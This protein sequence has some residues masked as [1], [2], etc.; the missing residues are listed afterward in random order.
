MLK[1][2]TFPG[3]CL[4]AFILPTKHSAPNPGSQ[5]IIDAPHMKQY[6]LVQLLSGQDRTQDSAVAVKIQAAHIANIERLHR[7]G[8][9]IMA[10]PMG[11]DKD[12]RGIFILDA[13]DSA[14]AA[15]LVNTDPAVK[16]GRLRFE[17]HPW[18]CQTGTYVFK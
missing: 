8:S 5:S 18:W 4:L 16:A 12:W 15:S 10:G 1:L 9:L 6:W 2:L 11:Y 13:K 7:E 3:L 14:T 17:L